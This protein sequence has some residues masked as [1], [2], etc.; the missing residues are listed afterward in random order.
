MV[1]KIDWIIW[2]KLFSIKAW[3]DH[4]T[5]IPEESKIKVFN[6]GTWVALKGM[7]PE[8]G[9]KE[10]ISRVGESLLWK[11]AQ[12]KEKK[13]NTSEVINKIMPQ[14]KPLITCKVWRPWKVLSR[15]I[16]RHH[17]KV[18]N[19]IINIPSSIR[20][21][22]LIINHFTIPVTMISAAKEAEIGHGLWS[23]KW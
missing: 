20:F 23:T 17:W 10:P 9:Q 15:V 18:V 1:I 4:V 22:V 13:N 16:S 8:G 3:W 21:V 7:I 6:K 11:K 5:L 12:K 2:V 14:R 19:I